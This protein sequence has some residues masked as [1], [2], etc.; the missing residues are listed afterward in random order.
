MVG[1]GNLKT[2]YSGRP[3]SSPSTTRTTCQRKS[4]T[5][6]KEQGIYKEPGGS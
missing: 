6:L 5:A 1:T 2:A 3:K 4:W